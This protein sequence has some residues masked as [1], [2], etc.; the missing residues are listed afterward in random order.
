MRCRWLM[1][2]NRRPWFYQLSSR[3]WAPS[4]R[5]PAIYRFHHLCL[6]LVLG[7]PHSKA[8]LRSQKRKPKL[9]TDP[10]QKERYSSAMDRCWLR[11]VT[12]QTNLWKLEFGLTIFF[13]L[14][15]LLLQSTEVTF[16]TFSDK[17]A[18]INLAF[19]FQ[20][21]VLDLRDLMSLF[22]VSEQNS[23]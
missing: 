16:H 11:E 14:Y 13:F 19:N 9:Q 23:C 6:Q 3:Q 10:F 1:M 5:F 21:M 7:S 2:R 20:F 4:H 17:T 8:A 12:K 15:K 18:G 22:F